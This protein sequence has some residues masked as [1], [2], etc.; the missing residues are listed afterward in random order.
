MENLEGVEEVVNHIEVLPTSGNDDRLRLAVY[1]A[2]YRQG[3]LQLYSMRSLPPMHVIVKNGNVTLE[4]VVAN[5]IDKNVAN[6][7]GEQ[8]A[9]GLLPPIYESRDCHRRTVR[10]C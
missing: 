6:C 3:S 9:W 7:S 1:R 4:G 2:I 10:G 8:R 5:E